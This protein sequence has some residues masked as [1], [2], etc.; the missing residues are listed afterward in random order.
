VRSRSDYSTIQVNELSLNSFSKDYSSNFFPFGYSTLTF[1]QVFIG[2][3][4]DRK[5]DGFIG[6]IRNLKLFSQYY[7]DDIVKRIQFTYIY[8]FK[9]LKMQIMLGD[10]N[11]FR[12]DADKA[13]AY[14]VGS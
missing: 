12:N 7:D 13:V 6:N 4:S 11:D 5:N 9:D 10:V 2:I 1:N 3:D 14:I 8:P